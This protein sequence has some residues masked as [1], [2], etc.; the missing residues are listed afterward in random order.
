MR[1]WRPIT[2]D[3][4]II[5]INPADLPKYW[6]RHNWKMNAYYF[7]HCYIIPYLIV[8]VNTNAIGLI[9]GVAGV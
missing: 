5:G 9:S 6:K 4:M 3:D 8:V 2:D 1:P 7:V